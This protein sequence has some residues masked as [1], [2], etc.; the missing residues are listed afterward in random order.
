MVGYIRL[1]RAPEIHMNLN[2]KGRKK[3]MVVFMPCHDIAHT[4]YYHGHLL[5][6][7]V[8]PYTTLK[9]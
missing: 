1:V 4:I 2:L 5:R 6:V 7:R 8:F 3:K 9:S